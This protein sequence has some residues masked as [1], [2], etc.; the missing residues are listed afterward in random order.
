MLGTLTARLGDPAGVDRTRPVLEHDA[1]LAN[2]VRME[3]LLSRVLR[4][5][6]RVH[7]NHAFVEAMDVPFLLTRLAGRFNVDE[8]LARNGFRERRAAGGSVA[9][10]ELIVPLLQGWDSVV[11]EADVELGGRDQLFNFQVA[12]KLQRAEGQA[13]EKALMVP[14]LPG[15]DGRKMSKSSG[16]CVWID[17]PAS[18]IFAAGM[19][20]SDEVVELW[21]QLLTDLPAEGEG[22][23]R[24]LA[25]VEAV[26]AEVH[27]APEAAAARAWWRRVVGGGKADAAEAVGPAPLLELVVAALACSKS[28]ARRL[29]AGRGVRV[30][31]EVVVDLAHMPAPGS[32]V[33]VGRRRWLEV[34]AG[35]P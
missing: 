7:R 31:G 26:V 27:G 1:V 23:A 18:E 28:H 11:L 16:N 29:V 15:L 24:K 17:Q 32:L 13:P 10:H 4:P 34:K 19:G 8:V 5:G 2:A 33:R 12:R 3:V 6:F 20:A 14:L 9:L 21:R 25:S 30:D 22:L 35:E